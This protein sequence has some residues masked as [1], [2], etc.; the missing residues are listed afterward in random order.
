[1]A[2]AMGIARDWAVILLALESLILSLVPL[3]IYWKAA[4]GL[5]KLLPRVRPF[6]RRVRS[7]ADQG[8]HGVRQAAGAIE[9]PFI[10]GHAALAAVRA[11]GS[12]L[13]RRSG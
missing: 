1:M 2:E 4:Q 11:F 9:R 7:V 10:A 12:A 5:G 6:L 3:F 8:T 13:M